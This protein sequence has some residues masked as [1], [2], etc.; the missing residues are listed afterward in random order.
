VERVGKDALL[1]HFDS[2]V[3]FDV[4]SAT[5]RPSGRDTLSQMA[6]VLGEYNKTAVIVQGHTDS[7]GTETHN[8]DLSER[9]AQAARNYLVG[10]GVDSQRIAALGFGESQPVATNDTATDRQRNRRVEVLLKAKA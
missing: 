4:D 8:Q 1:V 9:R 3:L 10:R 5:I 7:T 2:D 6:E